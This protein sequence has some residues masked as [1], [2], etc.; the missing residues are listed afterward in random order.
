MSASSG[1]G[2]GVG[3]R[4]LRFE[5][6][7]ADRA[8]ARSDLADLRMHRAGVDRAFRHA[9]RC[10][11]A[12]LREIL[13]RIGGE[14]GAAAGGAE[15][16]GA[17]RGGCGDAASCADRPSC[18]RPDRSRRPPAGGGLVIACDGVECIGHGGRLRS[19][20]PGGYIAGMREEAKTSC[21]RRLNR[22]EGQ[23]RGLEVGW[24][25]RHMPHGIRDV[26]RWRFR[27]PTRVSVRSR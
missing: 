11:R 17:G 21:L 7:A 1:L 10:A 3:G 18:R 8:G 2:A 27:G 24:A 19:D 26:L 16:I 5:R 13:F 25:D 23:V 4:D 6:H 9:R 20:T 12:A 14:L 22:I 15:I